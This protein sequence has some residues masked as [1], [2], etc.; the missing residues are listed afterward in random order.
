MVVSELSVRDFRNYRQEHIQL[1]PGLNVIVG[2]NGQGK[3]N[4]MEAVHLLLHLHSF[5]PHR[6]EQLLRKGAP[7]AWVQGGL[8]NGMGMDATRLEISPAGRRAW[9]ND[10]LVRKLSEHVGRG[11]VILF[12]PEQLYRYRH[13]PAERRALLDRFLSFADLDYSR[14]LKAYARARNQKNQ[15]LKA[16]QLH[17][18]EA[19]N[20]LLIHHGQALVAKRHQLISQLNSSFALLHKQLT[21]STEIKIESSGSLELRYLPNLAG[22]EQNWTERM[23]QVAEQEHC[24][25]Y[26]LVGPHRDDIQMCLGVSPIAKGQSLKNNSRSESFFSQGE[27]RLALLTLKLAFNQLLNHRAVLILDDLF[28]ELDAGIKQKL[29]GYLNKL[30]NQILITTTEIDSAASLMKPH[31]L[32]VE[33]GAVATA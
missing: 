20:T 6:W 24:L 26:T 22:D 18:L 3:T 33:N 25:G 21:T 10:S 5:R 1:A 16:Q 13:Q 7:Q 12:N 14:H 8:E 32:Q 31:L 2:R 11:C 27:Y 29:C 30:P 23:R 19:W 4:L 28:S 15:L 17:A 9:W